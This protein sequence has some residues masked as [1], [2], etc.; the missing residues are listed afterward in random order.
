MST[1][2]VPVDPI[3]LPATAS[4]ELVRYHTL[5]LR[6]RADQLAADQA[7]AQ[8][9]QAA[10]A[11]AEAAGV[12]WVTELAEDHPDRAAWT[13]A[14]AARDTVRHRHQEGLRGLA[15]TVPPD[16]LAAYGELW[17]AFYLSDANARQPEEHLSPSGRYRLVVTRH[18]TQPGRWAYSRGVVHRRDRDEPIAV[19]CRNYS[20]FPFAWVEGHA[21]TG[22]DYLVCGA[23]YQGQTFIDLVDSSRRDH[24]P[25]EAAQGWGFC[26]VAHHPSPDGTRLAVEGCF[27]ACPYEVV[28]YD[29]SEPM[30][31]EPPRELVR[32]GEYERFGGWLDARSCRV[33]RIVRRLAIDGHPLDGRERVS[34]SEAEQAELEAVTAARGVDEDELVVEAIERGS[35]VA[36]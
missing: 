30:S 15:A 1:V 20:H 16:E 33:D 3:E 26:W 5:F 11:A 7:Q 14:L 35:I 27:W 34:L 6:D 18:P 9:H 22:R 24:L 19:V 13:A 2:P 10:R 21:A 32:V 28:I 12:S 25:A 29:L 4:P 31:P 8:A 36:C 23:D 17:R